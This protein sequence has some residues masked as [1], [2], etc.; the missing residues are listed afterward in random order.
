MWVD[1]SRE[2]IAK[3]FEEDNPEVPI[4]I[5]TYALFRLVRQR[6]IPHED[7]AVRPVRRRLAGRRLLDPEQRHLLG[8]PG[9]NG[10]QPFAV[11]LNKGYLDP[12]FLDG[13]THGAL[14]PMTVD[15]T[16]YGLRND[17]APVLFWYDEA[18]LNEFGYDTPTTWEDYQALS[19]NLAAEHPG[20]F[21]GSIGDAFRARTSTSGAAGPDLPARRHHLQV[22][23]HRPELGENDRS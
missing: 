20:Y 23:F 2:P 16:V 8:L 17:L 10:I 4:E 3:A 18:L 5:E 9:S 12:S 1:A 14:D 13:F 21:L 11:A 6:L 22:R 19:D 7:R 15:G